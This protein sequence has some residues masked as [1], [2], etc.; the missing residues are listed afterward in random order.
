MAYK[1]IDLI[2][3]DIEGAEGLAL[4]GMLKLLEKHHPVI[5]TEFSP[6]ALEDT[7]RITPEYYL[8]CLHGLGYKLHVLHKVNGPSQ[9]S[10]SNR[11]IMQCYA[12]SKSDHID[13]LALPN[14]RI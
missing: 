2:K 8:N 6:N 11:E 3:I 1:K 5:F 14:E 4:K 13:L 9:S 10:L 7:S 12:E